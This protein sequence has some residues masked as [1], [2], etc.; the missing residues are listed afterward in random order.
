MYCSSCGAAVAQGLSYCNHC[1]AGLSGARGK[2]SGK[3]PE[4][5]P[6]SLIWAIVAVFTVGLGCT[7]GLMAVMK[8]YN[9]D[10]ELIIAF[11]SMVLLLTLA[12]E[13]VFIWMLWG[14][15]S[16]T[17]EV[18]D[19]GRL[20]QQATKELEVPQ[21]RALPEPVSSVTEHTT[22]AFEPIYSERKSK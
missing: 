13:A 8:D 21:V 14:R 22:R 17:A 19:T 18:V 20:K 12:V 2:S 4:L 3:P 11:T 15:R 6:D 7:I 10:K 5:F 1:G 9:F 16:K